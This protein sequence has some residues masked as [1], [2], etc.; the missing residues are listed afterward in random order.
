VRALPYI[1][2]TFTTTCTPE[3]ARD[4]VAAMIATRRFYLKAPPEPFR[5]SVDG[6]H[7]KVMRVLGMFWRNS[8]QP[9]IVGDVVQGATGDA[10]VRIRMRLHL[11]VAA[12]MAF[13]FGGLV[14]GTGVFLRTTTLQRPDEPLGVGFAAIVGM[15]AVFAYGLMSIGFWTEVKRARLLLREGLGV[16]DTDVLEE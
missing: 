16:D 14:L 11:A 3:D 10:E 6:S 13:W 4:R 5:G 7:F 2:L 9:V 8:F 1:R 15:M 12:F